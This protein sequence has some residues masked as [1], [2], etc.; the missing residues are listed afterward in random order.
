MAKNSGYNTVKILISYD[1]WCKNVKTQPS[2]VFIAV[3][4]GCIE[5]LNKWAGRGSFD[6]PQCIC[7]CACAIVFRYN[8]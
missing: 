4:D 8:Y 2:N 7:T 3:Y 6:K 1:K 5:K